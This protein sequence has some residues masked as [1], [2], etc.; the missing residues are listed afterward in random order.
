MSHQKV[1]TTWIALLLFSPLCIALPDDNREKMQLIAGTA[2]LDQKTHRG[3]FKNGV[4]IDQGTTHVRASYAITEG[5]EKNQLIK[6]IIRGN[7]TAQAHYWTTPQANKPPL[8]AYADR[9]LYFPE[10]HRIELVGHARIVQGEDSFSAD[11]INYD[12]LH[13]HVRS[14]N[15][16]KSSTRIII[17]TENLHE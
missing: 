13:Q 5:N 15:A 3:I 8:H 4:E 14:E 6:A 17:H 7:Q 2:L 9:I 10:Q 16:N 1:K 12:I 11:K